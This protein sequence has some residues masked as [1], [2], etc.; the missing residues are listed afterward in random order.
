MP[1]LSP[2]S[3]S[4]RWRSSRD[5]ACLELEQK[6]H[7]MSCMLH[8][9]LLTPAGYFHS[10]RTFLTQ[11]A[12]VFCVAAITA[13]VSHLAFV[14]LIIPTYRSL[15]ICL[16]Y[17]PHLSF[18]ISFLLLFQTISSLSFSNYSQT[19]SNFFTVPH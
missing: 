11:V 9:C 3:P 13:S 14:Q 10:S 7:F 16:S 5:S 15:C 18:S 2:G 4:Q 19:P 12:V 17:L 1:L 8:S 6:E